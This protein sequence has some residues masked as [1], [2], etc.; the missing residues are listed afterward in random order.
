MIALGAILIDDCLN[1]TFYACLKPMTDRW[2]PDS[3]E[4]TGFSR[5]ETLSFDEPVGV[6]TQFAAW[7]AGHSHGQL[8]FV[9]DNNG[10]DW[11]FVNFYFHHFLGYNP[12]G[13]RSLHLGSLYKGATRSMFGNF[14]HLRR[15]THTHHALDDARGNAEAFLSLCQTFEVKF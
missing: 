4:V 14:K 6:M 3:L 2:Q 15:T 12:F 13:H 7:L 11:Q 9:S 1:Q 5:E 8:H 10:F